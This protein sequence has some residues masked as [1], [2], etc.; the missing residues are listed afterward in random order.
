MI[1]CMNGRAICRKCGFNSG[2]VVKLRRRREPPYVYRA[3]IQAPKERQKCRRYRIVEGDNRGVNGNLPMTF[4]MVKK[5]L[6]VSL[7][8]KGLAPYSTQ[9]A[10]T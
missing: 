3:S 4:L 1:L 2:G 5:R 8:V 10:R 6:G 9:R 7:F